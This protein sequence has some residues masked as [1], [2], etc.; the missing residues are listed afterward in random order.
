MRFVVGVLLALMLPRGT[1]DGSSAGT[2][3]AFPRQYPDTGLLNSRYVNRPGK[4]ML[5]SRP[6]T[7][8]NRL[9]RARG[10]GGPFAMRR[11]TDKPAR[12]RAM[13]RYRRLIDRS[14]DRAIAGMAHHR[15]TAEA[16]SSSLR[17]GR[18][19]QAVQ[20]INREQA[21]TTCTTH[22]HN[23]INPHH[24][25]ASTAVHLRRGRALIDG[26]HGPLRSVCLRSTHNMLITPGGSVSRLQLRGQSRSGCCG[27]RRG[28]RGPGTCPAAVWPVAKT[29]RCGRTRS[30]EVSR[31]TPSVCSR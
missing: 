3:A 11:H 23:T 27:I 6:V 16:L 20:V 28:S 21:C 19:C 9:S 18:H 12:V 15:I 5:R 14:V 10:R 2:C 8:S 22:V 7:Y 24:Q 1:V 4:N 26:G 31:T 30:N 29:P 13:C 17:V 25:P